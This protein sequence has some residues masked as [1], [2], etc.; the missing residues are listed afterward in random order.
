MFAEVV[1]GIVNDHWYFKEHR[2]HATLPRLVDATKI[3]N[4]YSHN[5]AVIDNVVIV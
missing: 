4:S 1:V 3:I 5:Y 2:R